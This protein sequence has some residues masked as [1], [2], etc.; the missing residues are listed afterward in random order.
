MDA[1]SPFM[2]NLLLIETA[3]QTSNLPNLVPGTIVFALCEDSRGD[4]QV[5][6]FPIFMIWTL[7]RVLG[8]LVVS[9]G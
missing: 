5:L 2:P 7:L 9:V 6:E 1:S 3:D 4:L 8:L